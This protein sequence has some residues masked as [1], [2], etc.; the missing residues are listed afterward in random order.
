MSAPQQPGSSKGP[1]FID[2]FAGCGGFSLGFCQ[3]GWQG[4]FAV[5]RDLSAFKTFSHNFLEAQCA[6]PFDWPTAWLPKK[7][8]DIR[9][10]LKK[11]R[12]ELLKMRGSIDAV[13]GGPPCQG[14]SF[15]GYRRRTDSRNLLFRA[16]MEFVRTVQPRFVLI[17]N[18]R[19]I[20]IE[21]GKKERLRRGRGRPAVPF[22]KRIVNALKD[23]GYCVR[24]PE[25]IQASD[26][27]V[28]QRRPRVFFFAYLKN[29]ISGPAELFQTLY[30]FR[31]GFLQERSLPVS[32]PVHVEEATSDLLEEHGSVECD[33]KS[34]PKGFELGTYGRR[35][36]KYQSLLRNGH[37]P[38]VAAQSHRFAKHKR[39]TKNRFKKIQ[40]Q[41][42]KGVQLHQRDRQELDI[43][44]H[45]VV[46][47]K[48]DQLGHTLTTLPDDYIHYSEP[49]ILTVREYA[50][51]QSFPDEFLFDGP[52]TSGG[53]RRKNTC[54]R[55]T[56]IGNAV[57]PLL[58]EALALA[59]LKIR[60]TQDGVSPK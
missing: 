45:V 43:S 19:G 40:K 38:G 31:R 30:A 11:Y 23:L 39:K 48:G 18:V 55:Y 3:A 34:S 1:R 9:R 24:E 14:F 10:V 15:A 32:R 6:H 8:F 22:A 54:P 28:P 50:R 13:I 4:V 57:P 5:E 44:K 52:F 29:S 21:H 60:G 47:L 51:L 37:R 35:E 41:C 42:R 56:Q 16:Y 33:D 25:L 7:N 17:E 46:P 20:C 2:L 53:D 26:F 49:R 27:G 12:T 59:L 58:G 36:S